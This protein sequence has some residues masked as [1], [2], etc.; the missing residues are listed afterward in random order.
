MRNKC[1]RVGWIKGRDVLHALHAHQIVVGG[2]GIVWK[3]M[4]GNKYFSA[5]RNA[6][7]KFKREKNN[8]E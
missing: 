4:N 3:V 7:P 1:L 2:S 8:K 6:G 5:E